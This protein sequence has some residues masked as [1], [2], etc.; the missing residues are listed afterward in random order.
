MSGSRDTKPIVETKPFVLEGSRAGLGFMSKAVWLVAP[1]VCLVVAGILLGRTNPNDLVLSPTLFWA[2]VA[3]FC[4]GLG[5]PSLV[6]L[7][8]NSIPQPTQKVEFF[9]QEFDVVLAEGAAR[10]I[11]YFEVD[12]VYSDGSTLFILVEGETLEIPYLAFQTRWE[13]ERAEA[14]VR[15]KLPDSNLKSLNAA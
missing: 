4:L 10:S 3:V 9:S 1:G 6:K 8:V 11:K 7:L 2:G 13:L 12:S 15:S 14:L 5:S